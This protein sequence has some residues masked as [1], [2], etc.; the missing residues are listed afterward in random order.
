M[1][2]GHSDLSSIVSNSSEDFSI[3]V[4]VDE[5]APTEIL[6]STSGLQGPRGPTGSQGIVGPIGPGVSAGGSTFNVLQKR[7][8]ADYDTEW[9]ATPTLDSLRVSSADASFQTDLVTAETEDTDPL[10]LDVTIADSI[11]YLIRVTDGNSALT[12]EILATALGESINF[13][14]YGTV[15][16]G[17]ALCSF[18]LDRNDGEISLIVTPATGTL[19]YYR[20]VKNAI[21]G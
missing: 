13:V 11:K 14:E 15:L 16:V 20:V 2:S 21:A 6:I 8:G 9:T 12:T 19:T 18:E 3:K 5:E 17:S 1:S 4:E 7:T 10:V